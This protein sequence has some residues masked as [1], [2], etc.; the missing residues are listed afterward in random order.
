MSKQNICHL[1]NE[2]IQK[3][4][5]L[6]K[7]GRY[8]YDS[9]EDLIREVEYIVGYIEDYAN[10]ALESGQKMEDRLIEY[11]EAIEGLGFVR[12]K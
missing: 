9:I 12:E 4:K 7:L 8:S 5:E 6:N 10:E 1:H 11:K 3:C 2:I